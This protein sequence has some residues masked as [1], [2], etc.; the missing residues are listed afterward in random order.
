MGKYVAFDADVEGR[1]GGRGGPVGRWGRFPAV[2][3]PDT[4][5]H[6]SAAKKR[7]RHCGLNAG[8]AAH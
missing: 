1:R 6:A 8:A 3:V 4:C 5:R 2:A 7:G